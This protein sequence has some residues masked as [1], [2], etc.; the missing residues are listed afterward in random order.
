VRVAERDLVSVEDRELRAVFVPE[1]VKVAVSVIFEEKERLPDEVRLTEIEGLRL[2]EPVPERDPVILR[3][4]VD[5]R[6]L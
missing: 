1:T 6:V 2:D 4:A 5:D 3:V